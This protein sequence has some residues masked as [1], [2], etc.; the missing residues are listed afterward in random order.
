MMH[1]NQEPKLGISP[2]DNLG[3]FIMVT[4]YSKIVLV[5]KLPKL[6]KLENL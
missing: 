2:M 6:W 5:G 1:T 3:N 4:E